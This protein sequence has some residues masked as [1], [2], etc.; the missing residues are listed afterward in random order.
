M[1]GLRVSST[2][3]RPS[4]GLRLAHVDTHVLLRSVEPGSVLVVG[5][6]GFP[7]PTESPGEGVG[8][9]GR[10]QGRGHWGVVG[11]VS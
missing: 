8:S 4:P 2:R 11:G 10:S 1:A 6:E 5:V 7:L 9:E 3:L